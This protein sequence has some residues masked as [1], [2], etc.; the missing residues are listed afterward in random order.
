MD[1]CAKMLKLS[2]KLW[3]RMN[4]NQYNFRWAWTTVKTNENHYKYEFLN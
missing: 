1:G 2:K 4:Y 3:E